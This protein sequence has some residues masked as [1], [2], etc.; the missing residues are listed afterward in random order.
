[1]A[2]GVGGVGSD[3]PQVGRPG[4]QVGG[5]ATRAEL[6]G[7]VGASQERGERRDTFAGLLAVQRD[8]A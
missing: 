2:D 5:L 6:L 8:V 7:E 4:Q 1:M 3:L